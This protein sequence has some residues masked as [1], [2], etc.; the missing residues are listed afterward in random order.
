MSVGA[1]FAKLCLGKRGRLCSRSSYQRMEARVR[2]KRHHS[3]LGIR[4]QQKPKPFFRHKRTELT[5]SSIQASR[6]LLEP[7]RMWVVRPRSTENKK[8]TMQCWLLA[9]KSRQQELL[10]RQG[11][12]ATNPEGGRQRRNLTACFVVWRTTGLLMD[13]ACFAVALANVKQSTLAPLHLHQEIK[14]QQRLNASMD[15][16]NGMSRLQTHR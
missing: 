14:H 10:V 15:R 9:Q 13:A 1:T 16:S 11:L 7:A 12:E 2:F 3:G 8:A 5:C 4:S 6:L